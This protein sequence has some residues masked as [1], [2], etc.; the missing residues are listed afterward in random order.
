MRVICNL[1][2]GFLAILSLAVAFVAGAVIIVPLAI[3]VPPL[4]VILGGL[5]V[6]IVLGAT[7]SMAANWHASQMRR[8]GAPAPRLRTRAA[9]AAAREPVPGA[10]A[11]R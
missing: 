8:R 1:A 6:L 4:V 11:G 3:F 9:P 2:R 7:D 5:L 10:R